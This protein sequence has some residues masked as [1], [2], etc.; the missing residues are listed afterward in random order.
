MYQKMYNVLFNAITD[1]LRFAAEGDT[2]TFVWI[3]E[4]AQ[5]ETESIF[6][7]W[8]W[9]HKPEPEDGSKNHPEDDPS[10]S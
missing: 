10:S 4:E 5:R 2:K 7:E 1:A 9:E 6:M 3:L 8:D